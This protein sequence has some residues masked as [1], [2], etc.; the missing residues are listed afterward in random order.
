MITEALVAA[1]MLGFLGS[2]HC[3]GMCGGIAGALSFA[4]PEKNRFSR[5][6]LVVLYNVGRVG[7]YATIGAL[8]GLG[9]ALFAASGLPV[10]RIAAGVLLILMGLYLA[11]WWKLLAHLE[12]AGASVWRKLQPLSQRLVPVRTPTAA[13]LLG[14][15]WGWLPCG[16]VYSALAYG[17]VQGSWYG[18]ALVML[19]F[20][21]GTV[22]AVLL[23]GLAGAEINRSL[24]G[25][26]RKR[27]VRI[28]MALA[29]ILFGIWTISAVLGGPHDGH[30]AGGQETGGHESH[31]LHLSPDHSSNSSTD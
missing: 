8:A 27:K 23:G 16:L 20:G 24:A 19:A 21:L 22:P 17:A 10:L 18:G 9:G 13:L 12:K 3:L 7:S 30:K 6:A 31:S 26:A 28:V 2:G 15:M 11:D 25:F 14:M 1:F 4:I 29:Y 5:V